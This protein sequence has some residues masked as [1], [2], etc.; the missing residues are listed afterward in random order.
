M[1]GSGSIICMAISTAV[2]FLL[3]VILAI[4]FY[5]KEKISFKAVGVGAAIFLIFALILEQILHFAVLKAD[6]NVGSFIMHTPWLYGIYGGLAAGIFEETGRFVGYKYM[7]KGLRKWKD[8]IAYGIGH[9]GLESI[10]IGG[11][12]GINNLSYSFLINSGKFDSLIK[13]APSSSFKALRAAKEGLI[14]SSSSLY[15]ITGYERFCAVLF[16]IGLSLLVLY[17]VKNRKSIFLF[18]AI[19][20]HAFVDFFAVLYQAGAMGLAFVEILTG[21]AAVI[22]LIFIIKSRKIFKDSSE[23]EAQ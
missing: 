13:A 18:L 16:Q 12:A 14:S 2:S 8:G 19:F 15:L 9:G 6:K 5:K 10:L 20:L 1:V 17:A 7:L 3:P 21:I 4:V 23:I 22:S 11:L